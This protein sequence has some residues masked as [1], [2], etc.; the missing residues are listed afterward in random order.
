MR[1]LK[2]SAISVVHWGLASGVVGL[3][4]AAA[5]PAAAFSDLEQCHLLPPAQ[6]NAVHT[7]YWMSTTHCLV[8]L[9]SLPHCF[10]CQQQLIA[11]TPATDPL[12][13]PTIKQSPHSFFLII[14]RSL[15][16]S[17]FAIA[18]EA[19]GKCTFFRRRRMWTR[20]FISSARTSLRNLMSDASDPWDTSREPMS[21]GSSFLIF[22][23]PATGITTHTSHTARLRYSCS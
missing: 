15:V 4:A 7:Q 21:N 10:S 3:A 5:R 9:R 22:T 19:H 2:F 18:A 6:Y 14:S 20:V 12:Q 1:L 23:Q 13:G 11:Q 17:H 16:V 8:L